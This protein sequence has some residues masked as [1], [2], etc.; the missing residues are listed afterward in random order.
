MLKFFFKRNL[1]AKQKIEFDKTVSTFKRDLK[2]FRQK[3]LKYLRALQLSS[4]LCFTVNTI[5]IQEGLL[6]Y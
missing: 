5:L 1:N 6:Y 4:I 3:E 2:L